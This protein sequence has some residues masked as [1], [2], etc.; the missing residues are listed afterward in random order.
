M[1][2]KI[3]GEGGEGKY[4]PGVVTGAKKEQCPERSFLI[5]ATSGVHPDTA[6]QENTGN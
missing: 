3:Y 6:K 5:Q 4:S 2:V 1:L